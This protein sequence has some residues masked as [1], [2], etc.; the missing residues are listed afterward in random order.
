MNKVYIFGHQ[1]PDT[2]AVTSAISLSYLKNKLG[3]DT[4]PRVLGHINKETKYVLDKFGVK[5]PKYLN[6]VKLQ[7]KDLDYHKGLFVDE[8]KSIDY[9]YKF[10]TEKGVTGTP[11]VTDGNKYKGIITIKDIAK[12]LIS[13]DFDKIDSNY[14][15]I[16]ETVSGEEVL[17][18][19]DEIKGN[20]L[21]ASY[22]SDTFISNVNLN[23]NSILIVGDRQD[24]IKKAI[25]DN[26]KLI[27]VT[28]PEKIT[29]E[30]LKLA[31]NN[32]VNVIKTNIDS[33]HTSKLICLSNKI[34]T[35][36]VEDTSKIFREND[37]YTDFV[38]ASKKLKHN[39]YPIL[40]NDGVCLGLIRITE[41]INKNN[42]K[43]MLVD[44]QEKE[45]SVIGLDEANILEI[46][47]HHKIGNI[48]TTNP[49]NFRNM[50]VGSTNTIVYFMYKEN[51]VEIPKEIAGIMLSGLLSDT[52]CLQSP[53]T[54]EIDKKVA[55]D[56]ALIAGVDYKK[57][58][59][60][61]FKAGTSLEG[62]TK[63]EVIKSDFKSF[64]IGDE[65][66]AIGQVFTL[67][68]DRIFDELDTYIEKLE[69][70]NNKEG[71]KFIIIA[72][73]DILKNGSYLIFTEN[74]KSVLESIYKLDDIKQGYYVD[75]LV[76]RKKQ[77][78]PAILSELN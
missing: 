47:D 46:V 52:L 26:V 4:E 71:Y 20:V 69:E 73:T 74:A 54:T 28:G 70:I 35:L 32:K 42:K 16:L 45:Q 24:I 30:N 27:V 12:K 39:N 34:G 78:L 10:L 59:L 64:P 67:D 37:Y 19:D 1:S 56:L 9:V 63:E 17:K 77:I 75:G 14:S 50:T 29:E 7:L 22:D 11:V 61:M 18:F 25:D 3:M 23:S 8:N 58:A 62:L 31:E 43:V 2:D 48:N 5:E 57:Y 21:V 38:E 36:L 49:I 60:D 76:S 41:I 51:N 72:I 6:D 66:M 15:N 13:N 55:E 33:F 53:T 65:K 44:H 40:N 68:V